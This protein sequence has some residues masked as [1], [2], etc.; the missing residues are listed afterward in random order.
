MRLSQ[1]NLRL[2]RESPK[3]ETSIN[4]SLLIKGGFIEKLTAG[5]YNYSPLGLKVIRKIENII[6]EEMNN[7]GGRELLLA[8]L[9]P[10]QNWEITGR[11]KNFNALFK[12]KSRYDQWYGLGPTHEEIIVPFAKK[13]IQS[14]KDL[15]LYLYQIQTKF[16]DEARPKSGLLRTKE[17]LMKDLYSFHESENDLDDYYEKV[18]DAY[19]KIFSRL[20]LPFVIAEAS[21]GTFS[22]YSHEFQVKIRTGEDTLYLCSSCSFCQNEEIISDKKKCLNCRRNLEKIK[23]SEVGN[24]FK[25]KTKYS[26]PFNL[27]FIDSKGKEKIVFMGCYGIGVSRLMGVI[28]EVY[29]DDDGIIWPKE[30][31]PFNY[32]LLAL[33]SGKSNEDK[34]IQSQA[35]KIYQEFNKKGVSIVF[36]DRK[37]FTNGEKLIDSDFLGMPQR[38]IIS[39]RTLEKDSLEIKERKTKKIKIIKIKSF[40]QQ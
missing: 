2:Q 17:F 21:G 10:R 12:T 30:A 6:R 8:A 26:E 24:I 28:V 33:K 19:S 16:R 20:E 15:P 4:A 14:Y 13:I 37:E 23:G 3:Y 18:K 40:L 32:H 39:Q 11:W 1:I 31:A 9:H 29:H 36:D 5:V 38:I 35:E 7:V 25:L 34:I 22:P 27:K